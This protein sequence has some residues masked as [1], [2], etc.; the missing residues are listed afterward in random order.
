[1]GD[2]SMKSSQYS[3]RVLNELHLLY[4]EAKLVDTTVTLADCG[5]VIAAHKCVLVAA[6]P[7]FKK[8]MDSEQLFEKIALKSKLVISSWFTLI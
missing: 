8:L 7:Y 6:F 4:N 5:T 3:M 1:M 2:C